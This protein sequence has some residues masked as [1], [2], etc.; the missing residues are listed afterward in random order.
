[1]IAKEKDFVLYYI[2]NDKERTEMSAVL[3]LAVLPTKVL[4]FGA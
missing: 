1:M 4:I 2:S 3:D